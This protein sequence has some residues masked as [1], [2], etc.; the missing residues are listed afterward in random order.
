MEAVPALFGDAPLLRGEHAVLYNML[1]GQ[2]T[3]LVDP[4][5][6]SEHRALSRRG[7]QQPFAFLTN[8]SHGNDAWG[9][10]P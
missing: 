3:N 2:F 5:T 4:T 7:D 9:C 10:D 1:M 8:A 6:C